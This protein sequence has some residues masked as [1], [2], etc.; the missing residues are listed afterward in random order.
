M[1]NLQGSEG[2]TETILDEDLKDLSSGSFPIAIF[3][4]SLPLSGVLV[5]FSAKWWVIEGIDDI[6]DPSSSK[7]LR[8][9]K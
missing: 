7:I 3:V 4:R 1:C 9:C 6:V 2:T 8:I 5:S